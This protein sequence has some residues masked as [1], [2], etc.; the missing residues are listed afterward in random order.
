M[1]YVTSPRNVE[2]L[3][4]KTG[5]TARH[6]ARRAVLGIAHESG[7]QTAARAVF[8]DRPD[9]DL[10]VMDADPMTGLECAAKL[11][12]AVR[13]LILDYARQARED[14]HSWEEIRVALEGICETRPACWNAEFFGQG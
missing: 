11:T 7:G 6:W 14:G 13:R 5:D 9:L 1:S 10:T 12:S 3:P 4:G 2:A 8:R